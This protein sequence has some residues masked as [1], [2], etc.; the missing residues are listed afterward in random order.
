MSKMDTFCSPFDEQSLLHVTRLLALHPLLLLPLLL[1]VLQAACGKPVQAD[2]VR[3]IALAVLAGG[4]TS[5]DAAI[6]NDF[7]RRNDVTRRERRPKPVNDLG[8][9]EGCRL[10]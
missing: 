9:G 6:G 1:P 4:V 8:G 5:V 7:V 3:R 2:Q 10:E